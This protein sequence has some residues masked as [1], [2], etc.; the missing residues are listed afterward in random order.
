MN[1][2]PATDALGKWLDTLAAIHDSLP[3]NQQPKSMELRD[4]SISAIDRAL[5]CE[6]GVNYSGKAWS[7]RQCREARDDALSVWLSYLRKIKPAECMAA[8]HIR[9]AFVLAEIK[10]GI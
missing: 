9:R 5:A 7:L 8:D 4:K 1:P 6:R 2:S 10:E 3:E